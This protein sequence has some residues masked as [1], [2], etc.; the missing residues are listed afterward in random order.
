MKDK[1]QLGQFQRLNVFTMKDI[2]QTIK[3]QD[4]YAHINIDLT[5]NQKRY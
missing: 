4:T 2:H 5:L 3:L 1:G